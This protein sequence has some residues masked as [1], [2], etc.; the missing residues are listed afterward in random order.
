MALSL[1]NRDQS[2]GHLFYNRR[3]R[4]AT[5]RFSVRMKHDDRKQTAWMM[6]SGLFVVLGIIWCLLLNIWKPQGIAG[7]SQIIGD[8]DNGALYA[9]IDGKLRPAQTLVSA[10]L[11]I[12]HP[13]TVTWV[14]PAEIDKYPRGPMVGIPG[15][16]PAMIVNTGAPSAWAVCDTAGS[17]RSGDKTVVTAIAGPLSRF[18]R[19]APMG[20]DT[21]VL[22]SFG[23]G[24]YAIWGG[25]RSQV[26]P[27]DRAVTSS[28][29]I[30]PAVTVPVA[31]SRALFDAMP[32]TEP[33]RV[34]E[35][36]LAGQDS[37]WLPGTPIGTVLQAQTTGGGTQFYVLLAD[38]VQ[39]ITSFVADLLRS[40]N[41]Y[42]AAAPRQVS[43]DVLVKTPQVTT[44]PVDY[45]PNGRLK[46]VDTVANPT[47]CVG[48]EKAPSDP[49]ARV[50]VYSG[51]GLPVSAGMDD[52]IVN[53]VRD[54]RDPASVE[55]DRVLMLPGATNF[56]AST[57]AVLDARSHESLFWVS[58]EGVR[59]G[60]AGDDKTVSALG[61]QPQRAQQAPWPLL[62]VWAPGPELSRAAALRERDTIPTGGVVRPLGE[63]TGGAPAGQQGP[64]P[65]A[66]GTDTPA[67][68][69]GSAPPPAAE[70]GN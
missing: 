45:Y 50:T 4:A 48:W 70:G 22:A 46:F 18:G 66:P 40:A 27:G 53:L 47:T 69:D 12:G 13:A 7:D 30:D 65:P 5:T 42:G 37:R 44:L 32:A 8:R 15:A 41:S 17:L 51:R 23:G 1:S 62:R 68:G 63:P 26:D 35:V 67:G 20:G 10:E 16:P 58:T 25:K 38:G 59:Y 19:A 43:P 54:D 57:S 21:A 6:A 2:S 49:Q 29:G 55:A 9:R 52:R 60:I 24:T 36:P 34:P 64:P 56:V 61:L 39:K 3:L 11:A 33:L 31:M 14:K 28:L